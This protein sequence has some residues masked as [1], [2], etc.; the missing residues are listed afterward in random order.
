MWGLAFL[1]LC[2]VIFAVLI[3]KWKKLGFHGFLITSILG[4]ILNFMIGIGLGQSI[5]GLVGVALLY[6]ILQLKAANGQSA[7]DGL[8]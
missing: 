3:F 2:N 6:G 1:G 7:W 8:E 4:L 5:A